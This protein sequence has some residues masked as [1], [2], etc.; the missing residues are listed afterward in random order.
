MVLS[1]FWLA[2]TSKLRKLHT[3]TWTTANFGNSYFMDCYL[4]SKK[5]KLA[6]TCF[7]S[8]KWLTSNCSSLVPLV[9]ICGITCSLCDGAVSQWLFPTIVII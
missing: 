6:P 8:S 3:W 4:P 2:V 7:I 1:I 9:F 5:Y